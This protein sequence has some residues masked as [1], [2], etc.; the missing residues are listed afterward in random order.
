M[1]QQI[2]LDTF[3]PDQRGPAPSITAVATIIAPVRRL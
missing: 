3:P 1:G 2:V